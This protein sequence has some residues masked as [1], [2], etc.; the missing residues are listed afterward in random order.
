MAAVTRITQAV[1]GGWHPAASYTEQDLGKR[2]IG[3]RSMRNRPREVRTVAFLL[4]PHARSPGVNAAAARRKRRAR[5]GIDA[6]TEVV[7]PCCP[8]VGVIRPR[9][10]SQSASHSRRSPW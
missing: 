1:G 4:H 10:R 3:G 2:L 8:T 6:R 9:L 5:P 7:F